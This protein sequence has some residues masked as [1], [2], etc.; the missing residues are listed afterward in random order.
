MNHL[1]KRHLCSAGHDIYTTQL[2]KLDAWRKAA[3]S[4]AEN[5]NWPHIADNLRSSD[6]FSSEIIYLL[7]ILYTGL[8]KLNHK[9]SSQSTGDP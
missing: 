5:L 3:T 6:A 9:S 4:W 8:K 2:G 1:L 7:D